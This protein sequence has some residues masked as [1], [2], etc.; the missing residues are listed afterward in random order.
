MSSDSSSSNPLR[1]V[2]CGCGERAPLRTALIEPNV[3][4]RFLGCVNY[5]AE[6]G[7]NFFEWA[8]LKPCPRGKEFG[9]W[10]VKKKIDLEKENDELKA[11]IRE[12]KLREEWLSVKLNSMYR[13]MKEMEDDHA[14]KMEE[15]KNKFDWNELEMEEL[16]LQV[17]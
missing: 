15:W 16:R 9:N 14:L 17:K 5:K 2:N 6:T 8:N 12:F 11:K 7:C 3:G 4:R 10:I 13:N 1:G